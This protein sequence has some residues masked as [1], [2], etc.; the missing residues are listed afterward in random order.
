[1]KEKHPGG[2]YV[3]FFS[4]MWERFSFYLMLGILYLYCT[5]Y[6]KGGL[7]MS[8]AEASRIYGSYIALVYFTPFLGGLLADRYLGYRRAV[9][10]GG[11]FMA[12]GHGLLAFYGMGFFYAGLACLCIGNGFFKPNISTLVGKLYPPGSPLRD[13]GFNIFYMGINIGACICNFVAALLRNNYG[14]HAAFGSAGVGMVISLII[15][16]MFQR[17]I[18][19]VEQEGTGDSDHAEGGIGV[20]MSRLLLPAAAGGAVGYFAF[21]EEI[22]VTMAF[23]FGAIPVVAYYLW[24]LFRLHGEERRRVSALYAIFFVVIIFWAIFHQNGSAL[25]AWARDDTRRVA[26]ETLTEVMDS[27]RLSE[28]AP[29]SYFENAGP[30]VPR[31]D[32][33]SYKILTDEEYEAWQE[34][35]KSKRVHTD[36]EGP[37]MVLQEHYDA[38]YLNVTRET[39]IL[40]PG[41]KVKLISTELF[42]SVNPFFVVLFTAPVVLLWGFL[43]RRRR[44][45]SNPTKICIG[46]VLTGLSTLVMLTAVFMTYDGANKVSAG[47]LVSAYAVITVGELCLSPMGLSLVTKLAPKSVAGLMMGGWFVATA[48]GNKLAGVMGEWW[49][50]IPHTTFFII[51]LCGAFFA[52]A[53]VLVLLPW[54]KRAMPVEN[55]GE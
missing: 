10:L 4:E 37:E 54:L 7:G 38:V 22:R 19:E 45:P 40:N 12:M 55:E 31:H 28:T 25:T 50:L 47:W 33:G 36:D 3:L 8:A 18:N 11:V 5:D 41:E 24:V 49:E 42:Q 34:E 39:P 14:W 53:L 9:I 46:M 6:E 35:M 21:G 1:M 13:R 26:D 2:L 16:I 44:E 17:K 48:I 15:F 43:R 32:K 52:A 27:M 20:I 29:A 30:G 51:M 23:L